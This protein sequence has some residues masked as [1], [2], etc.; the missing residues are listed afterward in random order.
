[1][2]FENLTK[3]EQKAIITGLK[4]IDYYDSQNP[5]FIQILIDD[6]SIT[7]NTAR[8]GRDVVCIIIDDIKE[9]ALYVDTLDILSDDDIQ[10]ELL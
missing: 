5:E 7:I 3:S 2:R 9:T 6:D 10:R 1:M 4:H 8:S